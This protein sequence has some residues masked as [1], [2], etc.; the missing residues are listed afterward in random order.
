MDEYPVE[1]DGERL[2]GEEYSTSE[3]GFIQGYLNEEDVQQCAE[4]DSALHKDEVVTRKIQEE[5]YKFC[6]NDCAD[7]FEDSF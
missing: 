4:C 2:D 1:K 7:D 3:E 5:A 6:S